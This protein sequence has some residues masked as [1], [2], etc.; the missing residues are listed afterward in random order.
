MTVLGQP[1]IV[2]CVKLTLNY[3]IFKII[4]HFH[5]FNLILIFRILS[6]PI[7]IYLSFEN[8]TYQLFN[9]KVDHFFYDQNNW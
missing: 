8:K 6:D 2:Q 9:S 3:L 4:F 5:G 1:Y 7:R